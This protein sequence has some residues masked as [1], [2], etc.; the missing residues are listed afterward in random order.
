MHK[1]LP[2]LAELFCLLLY[3]GLAI[4]AHSAPPQRFIPVTDVD[5]VLA[6][7]DHTCLGG[8]INNHL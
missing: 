5:Q 2:A 7:H 8:Q 6:A 3:I 1:R 4:F